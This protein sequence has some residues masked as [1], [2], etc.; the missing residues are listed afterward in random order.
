MSSA[1]CF[2][3]DQSKIFSSGNGLKKS[4]SIKGKTRAITK[5]DEHPP[6]APCHK[7][8]PCYRVSTWSD[9]YKL[10]QRAITA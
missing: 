10:H 9:L 1:I 3:L 5:G 2:N 6:T 7:I 4:S 8:A